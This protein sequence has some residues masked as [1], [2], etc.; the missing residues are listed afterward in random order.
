MRIGELLL[1]PGLHRFGNFGRNGRTCL[2]IEVDHA[3][4]ALPRL[5][6]LRHSP[7]KRA[8]SASLVDGPKLTRMTDDAISSGTAIAARTRLGFML[9][10]EQALPADTA[11][12]ARSSCTRWLELA[13]PGIGYARIV[14]IRVP[15]AA[16]TTPPLL[17]ISS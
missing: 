12:P 6:I 2:I 4:C 9:P 8:M 16:I 11:M 3:A 10:D 7:T 1:D 5:A 15:F 14:A 17:T 13:M